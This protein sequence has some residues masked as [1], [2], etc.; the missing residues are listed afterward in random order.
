MIKENLLMKILKINYL[1]HKKKKYFLEYCK[2]AGFNINDIHNIKNKSNNFKILF[3]LR[4]G[5]DL[6]S[7]NSKLELF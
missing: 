1:I 4:L 3:G 2:E 5:I 7:L 6:E